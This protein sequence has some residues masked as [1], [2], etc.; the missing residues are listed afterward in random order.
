MRW[1]R[2]APSSSAGRWM[3]NKSLGAHHAIRPPTVGLPLQAP[4]PT[5]GASRLPTLKDF[6]RTAPGQAGFGMGER[7]HSPGRLV[8]RDFPRGKVLKNIASAPEISAPEMQIHG[9]L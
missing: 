5:C 3:P 8:H 7:Q 4:L 9:Y 6:R 1:R 2:P